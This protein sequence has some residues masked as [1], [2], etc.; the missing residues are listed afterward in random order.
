MR[1]GWF[2]LPMPRARDE[3]P[4]VERADD[5]LRQSLRSGP[6]SAVVERLFDKL[7]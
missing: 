3:P 7:G 5:R 6:E 2:T 1:T 4:Y